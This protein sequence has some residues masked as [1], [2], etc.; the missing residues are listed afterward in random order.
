LFKAYG[1]LVLIPDTAN[2]KRPFNEIVKKELTEQFSHKLVAQTIS[3]LGEHYKVQTEGRNI[4]LFYL[5]DE[6]KRERIELINYI[7][8]INNL[9]L[10]FTE[11]EI[12]KELDEHPERF[13][14]NVI[15]R[16][17]FQEM[18]LPNIAFV[19]GGSELAYW[20][21]L[22]SVFEAVNIPYPVLIL[23]N[24][25]L[26]IEPKEQRLME[27]LGL[28]VL[29]IF[30]SEIDLQNIITQRTTT[31][32]LKL[33]D[34]QQQITHLYT[35]IQNLASAVDPTLQPHVAALHTRTLQ[36]IRNLE[37]KML[38]AEKRKHNDQL[39][40]LNTL[41]TKL[42][43]KNSLQER[44]NNFMPLYAKYGKGLIDVLYQQS[45]SVEGKFE[46]I[47]LKN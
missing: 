4:N 10:S 8:K 33:T 16:G 20:L 6:G 32:R 18:I 9:N 15:L 47:E 25:F 30:Q 17:V 46:V 40:Q 34:E 13:S 36:A 42:F 45:L 23:R 31:N 35:Q 29:D 24:S 21:E 43:P 7:Y 14:A 2:L 44:V 3:R 11:S 28:S 22:K 12:L 1:L 5:N 26:I 39:R 19:G 27:K 38:K 37:S 41:K